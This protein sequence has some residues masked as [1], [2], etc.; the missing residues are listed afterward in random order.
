MQHES[1]FNSVP[2]SVLALVMIIGGVEIAFWLGTTGLVGG[3]DAIGWRLWAI[4]QYAFAPAVLDRIVSLGDTSF[5][6]TRRFITYSFVNAGVLPVVFACVMLLAL[7]KFVGESWKPLAILV[8]YL[9]SAIGGALV[10]GFVTPENIPIFSSFP[11][12]YGL[13]GAYSYLRW[14][15]LANAGGKKWMAFSLIAFVVF[16]QIFWGLV[17]KLL[18]ALGFFAA[19]PSSITLYYGIASLSGFVVGLVLS[20]LIGPGGWTA[21]INRLRQR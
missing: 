11:A 16:I 14:L 1:P 12:V 15:E 19:D 18:A 2:V 3:A 5:Y 20:P 13:I 21:F 7:G 9:A 4:D 8:I 10:F 17:L 6:L